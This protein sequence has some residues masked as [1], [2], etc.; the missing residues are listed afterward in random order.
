MLVER[1]KV[2]VIYRMGRYVTLTGNKAE[3]EVN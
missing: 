3:W 1:S 2:E